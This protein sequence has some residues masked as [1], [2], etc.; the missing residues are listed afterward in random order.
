MA[1]W[2]PL[3]G[4]QG[5]IMATKAAIRV[6]IGGWSFDE[7]RDNFYP[8][9]LARTQELAYA[10]RQLNAIEINSTY[11]GTQKP[12]SFAKWRD[13]APED[14]VFAVK[15]NRFA[16]N[17]RVLAEAGESVE[18]FLTSGLAELGAKLGPIVWQFATTKKF[19]AA[20]F[21]AF[22]NLLP[23]ALDGL[24]LRHVLD[25]RHESFMCDEYLAL[26]RKHRAA[27]V[28]TDSPDYPSFANLTGDFVYARLMK[29][30]SDQPLGYTDAALDGW[31]AAAQ[32]WA[33]GAQPAGLPLVEEAR[34]PA[35]KAREVLVFYINGAKERA[36]HAAM[37][38]LKRLGWKA[39]VHS[40][41]HS[42]R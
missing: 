18:K 16:T 39:P 28:F 31:T 3:S 21:G 22:L 6:G 42:P 26:A 38:M 27:T 12:S 25:V 32:T 23:T 10:S 24:P 15:A 9:G 29:A 1:S 33:S 40:P 20:D 19:D 2:R 34:P 7:W 36:P 37:A 14:F 5:F 13:D 30:T 17:R 8:R 35:K 41:T 11:H 4:P